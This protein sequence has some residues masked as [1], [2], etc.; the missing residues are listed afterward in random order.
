MTA[1]GALL[2]MHVGAIDRHRTTVPV[3]PVSVWFGLRAGR[4]ISLAPPL[5]RPL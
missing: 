4:I 2:D 5:F 1:F 3:T